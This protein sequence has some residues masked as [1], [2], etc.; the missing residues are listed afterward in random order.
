[1]FGYLLNEGETLIQIDSFLRKTSLHDRHLSRQGSTGNRGFGDHFLTKGKFDLIF[2]S[3]LPSKV[4]RWFYSYNRIQ[5]FAYRFRCVAKA[6][7]T[8]FLCV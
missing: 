6:Y 1:M 2:F 7:G 4:Q 8:I 3:F 5:E